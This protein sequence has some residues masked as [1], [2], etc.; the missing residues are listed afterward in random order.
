MIKNILLT[1][2]II[3]YCQQISFAQNTTSQL[4]SL[5]NY[6]H[7]KY[8]FDGFVL[9]ADG[10]SVIYQKAFGLANRDWNIDNTIDTKFRLGSVSKQ[11]IGFVIIKLAEEGKFKL[12][13]PVSQYISEF[14]SIDRKN[15]TILNLLTHTSGIFDYTEMRDFNSMVLYPEDSLVRMIAS[16]KLNFKPSDKYSYS[17]SNFYLLTVIAEKVSE[18]KFESILTEKILTP[19]GMNNSGLDHN[20]Y[21]LSN[22]A[23]PYIHAGSGFV[24]GEYIQMGN[25][26]GGMYST[27]ND[28]LRW[29]LF[30]QE[31]LN[32]D[33]FM[34]AALQPFHLTD[35][36]I[37]I[38]SAGWCLL[39]DRIMHQGHINGFANQI[40]IDTV[41]HYTI[42]ILSNDDFKQLFVTGKI[43]SVILK[44]KENPFAWL[45]QKIPSQSL[46][47][48]AGIYVRGR[49]T[50]IS[51]NENNILVSY[52][53][54]R[55]LPMKPF[56]RD[57]FF[58][59]PFEGN[60]QF[61]RNSKSE[62]IGV[63]S[64]EDYKWVEW[65]K[66]K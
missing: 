43:I 10:N 54:K 27:A 25:V 20:D 14:N 3:I 17:N 59:E 52:I 12:D 32:A 26:A 4:D 29:S 36:T 2:I 9:V 35:G 30:L 40:S 49:D 28:M 48:Y 41:N 8:Y 22:R 21:I 53:N 56:L 1:L 60:I 62:V 65:K 19:A 18:K 31:Q 23:S 51:K 33:R 66:I 16:H 63:S 61:E 34:K 46:N 6:M 24:N 15:I 7:I 42:I 58:T 39:S 45:M 11:F 5:L 55:A 44:R 38:Y 50:I 64:F 13:D 37:S 47:E 57:E